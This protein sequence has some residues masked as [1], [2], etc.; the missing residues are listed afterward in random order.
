MPKT[1]LILGTSKGIG[2]A[3][4]KRAL[5]LGFK[6]ISTC[7]KVSE[8][9]KST[10]TIIIESIDLTNKYCGEILV[11]ELKKRSIF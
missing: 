6:T 9:L 4:T 10:E 11:E 5:E 2:L 1:V 3:L 7:R 8:E